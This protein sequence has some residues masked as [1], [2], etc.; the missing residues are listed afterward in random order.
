M[1]STRPPRSGAGFSLIELLV[2]L[3]ILVIAILAVAPV[4][5]TQLRSMQIRNGAES[6]LS[7]LQRA[8]AEAIS[9][10]VNVRFTVVSNLTDGCTAASNSGSWI[11]SLDDPAGGCDPPYD[12]TVTPR[13][14]LVHDA[15]DGNTNAAVAVRQVNGTTAATNVTFNGLG[16]VVTPT[17]AIGRIEVTD[18][19][20]PADYRA[21]RVY[22]TP[23]GGARMCDMRVSLTSDDPRRC[24]D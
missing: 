21:Y 22:I 6:I 10:N 17:G 1:R 20:V 2:T 11:V 7:G 18:P 13:V 4:V 9:R 5:A 23:T 12:E 15:R 3:V 24:P 16:R 14:I 19:S 8:R